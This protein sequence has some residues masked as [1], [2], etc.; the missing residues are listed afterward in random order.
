VN[1]RDPG[2]LPND[3]QRLMLRAALLP[4]PEA[5]EAGMAWL[6]QADIDRLGKGARRLIPLLY[7]RLRAENIDHPLM[8]ILKGVKRHT[9]Y[10]NQLLLHRVAQIIQEFNQIG[11]NVLV[12]KGAAL[13]VAY[14][15]DYGLRPMEDADLLVSMEDVSASKRILEHLGW[16]A[17]MKLGTNR[18]FRR[19][20]KYTHALHFFSPSG[21]DVDL[22]WHLLPYCLQPDAD[23][24]FW[25][26]SVE[27][28]LEDKKIR[29]LDPTDQLLHTCIH[30][31]SWDLM[32]PIRWI[33]DAIAILRSTPQIDWE[34]LMAQ[35]QK[36]KLTALLR[37]ALKYLHSEFGEAIPREV[38]SQVSQI[39]VGFFEQREYTGLVTP[40][41]NLW[42]TIRR[43]SLRF[44][45]VS[46]GTSLRNRLFSFPAFLC[47]SYRLERMRELPIL[48]C[49][50]LV[51][52]MSRRRAADSCSPNPLPLSGEANEQIVN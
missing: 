12:I 11:I 4:G 25:K 17:E 21:K 33:P 46:D 34:R 27:A 5:L 37:G 40:P 48:L 39:H 20:L 49:R 52:K 32:I 1:Q 42:S 15:H 22:H 30:G 2:R 47:V 31:I 45:H 41:K 6:A 13:T 10:N 29:I 38:V 36:R 18:C 24:D 23:V 16:R 44:I 50:R 19:V 35:A 26:A 14:Y 8:P 28:S 7:N 3:E 43:V 51:L 9:W